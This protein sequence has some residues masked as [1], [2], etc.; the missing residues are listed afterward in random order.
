MELVFRISDLQLEITIKAGSTRFFDMLLLMEC[1]LH[2]MRTKELLHACI[3][4]LRQ[5]ID[6]STLKDYSFMVSRI[7]L[8]V[9]KVFLAW[10]CY[11]SG[12]V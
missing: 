3:Y 10:V 9:C 8:S 2:Y 12:S 6:R 7:Q 11:V 1:F 4:L 5:L